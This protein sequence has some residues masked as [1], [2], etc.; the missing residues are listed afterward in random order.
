[1]ATLRGWQVVAVG[2]QNTVIPEGYLEYRISISCSTT[3][4]GAAVGTD[5][6]ISGASSSSIFG[7]QQGSAGTIQPLSVAGS[8]GVVARLGYP[9]N[10]VQ[11][12][13]AQVSLSRYVV[14]GTYFGGLVHS[15]GTGSAFHITSKT[16]FGASPLGQIRIARGASSI[17]NVRFIIE[18]FV[19][20]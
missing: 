5:L 20:P 15:S 4:P 9:E 17:T 18:A 13:S 16:E 1:M 11:N 7:V 10:Q 8:S 3:A 19:E 14:G 2:G 12:I 6:V